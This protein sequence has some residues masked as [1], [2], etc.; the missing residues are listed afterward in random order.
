MDTRVNIEIES[1]PSVEILKI[2][3]LEITG[4]GG[5]GRG[6]EEGSDCAGWEG[7]RLGKWLINITTTRSGICGRG[8]RIADVPVAFSPVAW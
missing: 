3:K 1:T 2:R 8:S 5:G 7:V 4:G 6:E